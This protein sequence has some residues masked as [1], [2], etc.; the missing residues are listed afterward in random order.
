MTILEAPRLDERNQGM[1]L[2]LVRLGLHTSHYFKLVSLI[3]GKKKCLF[4]SETLQDW[5]LFETPA[6]GL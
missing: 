5:T 3:Q 1:F 6:K 4:M 2:A